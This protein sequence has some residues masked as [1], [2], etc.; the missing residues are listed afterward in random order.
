MTK[1]NFILLSYSNQGHLDATKLLLDHGA[2]P[3]L[4]DFSEERFSP[5]D[6][7]LLG[8]HNDAVQLLIEHGGLSINRIQVCALSLSISLYISSYRLYFCLS[9]SPSLRLSSL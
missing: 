6:G 8:G 5:L 2:E 9:V 4:L 7:A 3:N 1:F